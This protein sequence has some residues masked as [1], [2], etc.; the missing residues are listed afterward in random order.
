MAPDPGH[1]GALQQEALG[2]RHRRPGPHQGIGERPRARAHLGRHQEERTGGRHEALPGRGADAEV[3][4]EDGRPARGAEAGDQEA[5]RDTADPPRG[6]EERRPQGRPGLPWQEEAAGCAGPQGHHA[7]RLRRRRQS[8]RSGQAPPGQQGQPLRGRCVGQQ[9]LAL[10]IRLWPEGV[11]GVLAQDWRRGQPGQRPGPDA[12]AS[13]HS[14]QAGG[15]HQ[16]LEGAWGAVRCGRV[17]WA[18]ADSSG[19]MPDGS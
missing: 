19:R 18:R 15:G 16:G 1:R 2:Q 3:Q 7:A 9:R 4:P 12:A 6:C 14:E 17:I 13:G 5:G 10:C 8:H 11:G